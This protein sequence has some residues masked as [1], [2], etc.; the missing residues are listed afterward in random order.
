MR[1][2]V[3]QRFLKY[4]TF[5]TTANPN[6]SNCPSSEGQR[7]FANYLVEELKSL[8]LE[9]AHVDENSYVM[10]TLRGNTEG[11]ETIGFISH[12]DTA[13]DVTGKNVKPK[14]IK[15]YDGKDIV[16]N[17][18]LNIIT[19]PKD[20]PDLKKFIG[21][22]LIV[23][24]GTTLLG[25]DDKAGISEIVTAIEYLVNNPEIK[26]G[27]IKIGFTPDEEI[28]R[29]ADLFNV[30]KFGA[31]YAYTI[32]GGIMGELQYENF[33]AAG[34]TIT[35]QGRNVHPGAAKNK[36]INALHIAAE[37]SQMFP[38]SERPETTEGYEGFYHLNDINGNVE[39]A[40]MVYIIRDHSKEKFEYRKQY[41]KD[42]ISKV[43]E[44]YNG[45]VTLELNDQY[46]NMKEKVEPVKFIV[47]IAEEAMKECDITPIIVP[48]RGGTD[49]ARLSFMG[50]PCPNIFTGGLNFHSKNEC[51]PIIALEKCSNLIV[52]IAQNYAQ[53]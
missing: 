50:L 10:A 32:D 33:N 7:V 46:Y 11:V 17:E 18:E 36:M 26:H 40:T 35:I 20:Y 47:D 9:D 43:S 49:G 5:D 39:N 12:L 24:D 19:S 52:K 4:V 1:E 41:M 13:P 3:V 14:I 29:G 31:K 34:A 6:N 28:G 2:N 51:I 53:R 44:K 42:A 22:D 30:E 45:R 25:A 23:T 16:L 37:I 48:I 27:D 21:E 8:G 15:N 38:Q